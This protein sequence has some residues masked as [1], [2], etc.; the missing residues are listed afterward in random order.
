LSF[1]DVIPDARTIWLFAEL[2]KEQNMERYLFDLFHEELSRHGLEAKGGCSIDGTFV[3][4]PRQHNSHDE[5]DQ[6]KSGSIP[7][8]FLII[9]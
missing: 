3:E 9:K 8:R 4:V 6:I 2:F 1:S 7:K 5:N